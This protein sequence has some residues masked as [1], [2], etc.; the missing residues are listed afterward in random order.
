MT[1][2]R[3]LPDEADDALDAVLSDGV[4][5][6]RVSSGDVPSTSTT[7]P[8]AGRKRGASTGPAS[9]S[10]SAGEGRVRLT[11]TVPPELIERARDLAWHER[12][13]LAHVVE[14]AIL[15]HLAGVERKAPI[16]QRPTE[17]QLKTGRPIRGRR[18]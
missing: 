17:A 18:A 4:K 1:A 13:P 9:E 12:R 16:P 7:K 15:A 11:V 6:E 5:G 8:D 14:D 3:G 10:T 2:R